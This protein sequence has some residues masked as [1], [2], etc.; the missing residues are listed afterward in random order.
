[1]ITMKRGLIAALLIV[2]TLAGSYQLYAGSSPQCNPGDGCP[3]EA[4]A[5]CE[6]CDIPCCD[7]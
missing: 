5:N 4:R 3:P 1:M 6:P 2:G 7:Q